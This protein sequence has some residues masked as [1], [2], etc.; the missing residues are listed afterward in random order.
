MLGLEHEWRTDLQRASLPAS[1]AE[2]HA[3]LAQSI[4]DPL[5]Q[6]SGMRRIPIGRDDVDPPI[7]ALPAYRSQAIVALRQIV[8][9]AC[10]MTCPVRST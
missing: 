10:V 6:A 7:Q 8:Q 2:Q 4:D 1:G 3:G 9:R 5:G